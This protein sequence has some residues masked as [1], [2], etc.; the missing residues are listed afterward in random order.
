MSFV[1]G[2]YLRR[3]SF[4]IPTHLHFFLIDK[5]LTW[6]KI[7]ILKRVNQ[8]TT[9]LFRHYDYHFLGDK[10]PSLW[11]ITY[12]IP[13]ENHCQD[14][15]TMQART[16]PRSTTLQLRKEAPSL[17]SSLC[18]FMRATSF[19][20]MLVQTCLKNIPDSFWYN[21]KSRYKNETLAYFL[22]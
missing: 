13:P 19:T 16:K 22:I 10:Y 8:S 3:F 12:I 11:L 18:L 17:F 15:T 9:L 6:T 20:Y 2:I 5:N 7:S 21:S 4:P 14:S 1:Y